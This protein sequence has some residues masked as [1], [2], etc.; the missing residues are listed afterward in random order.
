MKLLFF[1]KPKEGREFDSTQCVDFVLEQAAHSEWD[2]FDVFWKSCV[3]AGREATLNWNNMRAEVAAG[4][5]NSC[6]RPCGSL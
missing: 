6:G 3:G 1:V 5:N 2:I 4:P